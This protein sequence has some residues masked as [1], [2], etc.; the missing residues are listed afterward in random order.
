[1]KKLRDLQWGDTMAMRTEDFTYHLPEHLIARRPM[2]PRDACR[3]LVMSRNGGARRHFRFRDLPSLVAPGDL[4]VFN[5]TRVIPARLFV[6]KPTGGRRELFFLEKADTAAWKALVRPG[7]G[8]AAGTVLAVE[9]EPSIR[10]RVVAVLSDGC[11]LVQTEAAEKRGGAAVESIIERYGHTP[12]PPYIDRDDDPS[13]REAYQT[14]YARMPGAVAAP[15]AGLHFTDALM[16]ELGRRGVGL[17]YL[18]LHVGPGTFRPVKVDNP[19]DHP[20]HE[21]RFSIPP[22]T[23]D[24]IEKTRAGGGR[25]VA[26]G[27]TVVR[28]LEHCHA[29]GG[30]LLPQEG[31]TRLMIL[32]PWRFGLVD[33]L[34]TNFHLPKSTLLMLVSAF[35]GRELLL[36][37]YR[38][39]IAESYRFYSYGDAMFIV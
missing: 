17:S 34:I 33:G 29:A 22:D 19:A 23:V 31:T 8:V 3:L 6:R 14:I 30:R 35:A 10:L 13:D 28:V 38:E 25:I 21:E 26:V 37:A 20:M 9:E 15:T 36:D 16:E 4:L 12:L 11:R 39:A 18:T 32:P 7:R 24:R 27:T 5:D 1:M 2:E